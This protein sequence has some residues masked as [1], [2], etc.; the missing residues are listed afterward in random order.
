MYNRYIRL[1]VTCTKFDKFI[2]IIQ[3]MYY[4]LSRHQH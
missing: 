4:I 3:S 2:D 1:S